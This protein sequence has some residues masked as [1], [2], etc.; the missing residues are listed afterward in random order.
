MSGMKN[1][2]KCCR[3]VQGYIIQG[4]VESNNK[5]GNCA[6]CKVL[7]RVNESFFGTSYPIHK[8]LFTGKSKICK[9][10]GSSPK[11]KT[12]DVPDSEFAGYPRIPD[13]EAGYWLFFR[14]LLFKFSKAKLF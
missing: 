8:F 13:I 10:K 12:R 1:L 5:L 7:H 6:A 2:L 9:K 11:V 3:V 4:T 14:F